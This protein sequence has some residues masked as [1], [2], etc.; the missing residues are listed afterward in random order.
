[1]TQS[2]DD[3]VRAASAAFGRGDLNALRDQFLA[4]NITWHIAGTGP[5]AGDYEGV[6]QVMALLEK[7]AALTGGTVRPEL[8]DV[9]VSADHTVALATIGAER[10]GKKLQLNLVHVIHGENGK[11]TEVWTQSSDPAAAA[12]FWS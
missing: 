12:K 11:A 9:L 7:V 3:M 4:E 2:R 6:G 8:H 10:A 1:M 5:L